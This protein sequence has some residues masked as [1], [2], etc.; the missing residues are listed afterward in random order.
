MPTIFSIQCSYRTLSGSPRRP[1][2][3]LPRPFLRQRGEVEDWRVR[4]GRRQA[5]GVRAAARGL[6]ASSL[7]TSRYFSSFWTFLLL[8]FEIPAL[9]FQFLSPGGGS[10]NASNVESLLRLSDVLGVG[11]GLEKAT[12]FLL[13]TRTDGDVSARFL[14]AHRFRHLPLSQVSMFQSSK[15][16]PDS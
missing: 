15:E 10:V 11:L 4:G 1:F 5:G 2:F 8:H 12:E 9:S 13:K 7:L 14:M 16:V 3:L 6:I